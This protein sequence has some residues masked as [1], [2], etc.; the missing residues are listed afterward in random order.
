LGGGGGLTNASTPKSGYLHHG[1]S[2]RDHMGKAHPKN[3]E[4]GYF[5]NSR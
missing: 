4:M 1:H 5:Q 3:M 2:Q